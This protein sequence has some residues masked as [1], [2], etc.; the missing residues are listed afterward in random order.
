MFNFKAIRLLASREVQI[1]IDFIV[2][3]LTD[4]KIIMITAYKVNYDIV[5]ELEDNDYAIDIVQ[6]PIAIVS[7]MAKAAQ[8]IGN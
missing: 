6:K 4:V 8:G 2:A 7:L 1:P 3:E 5:G